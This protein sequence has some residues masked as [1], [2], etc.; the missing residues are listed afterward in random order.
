MFRGTTP[1]IIISIN[2]VDLSDFTDIWVTFEQDYKVEITKKLSDNQ[3]IVDAELKRVTVPLTQ[4]D[5][6][7]FIANN[8]VHI[9]LRAITASGT[10]VASPIKS[11]SVEKILKEGVINDP[12]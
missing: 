9:Q 11:L 6:L 4:E 10:A 7:K 3:I 2:G 5:T 8:L 12:N 1:N